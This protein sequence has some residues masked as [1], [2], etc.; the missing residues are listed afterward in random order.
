META[1]A[2]PSRQT[3]ARWLMQPR[4]Q[5]RHLLHPQHISSALEKILPQ[6]SVTLETKCLIGTFQESKQQQVSRPS[7]PRLANYSPWGSPSP[8]PFIVQSMELKILLIRF[9]RVGKENRTETILD[10]SG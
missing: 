7:S 3:G 9:S 5:P 8:R 2:S 6:I 4:F 1:A 10:C